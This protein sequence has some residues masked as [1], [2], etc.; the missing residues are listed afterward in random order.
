MVLKEN[1]HYPVHVIKN[2]ESERKDLVK[3]FIENVHKKGDKPFAMMDLG[4]PLKLFK[5]WNES[6]PSF[7]VYYGK[8]YVHLLLLW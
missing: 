6:L 5:T 7:K 8:N 2:S 1:F 4:Q 3:Y